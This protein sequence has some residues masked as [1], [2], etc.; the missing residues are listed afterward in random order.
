[1]TSV[2]CLFCFSASSALLAQPKRFQP[3]S[4]YAHVGKADQEEGRKVLQIF[5]SRGLYPGQHYLEFLLTILPRRGDERSIPGR[6]WGTHDDRGNLTRI[7]LA[8]GVA[9]QETRLLVRVGPASAA[10][11][12][13]PG[14]DRA[15]QPLSAAALFEPLAGSDVTAFDLEMPFLYWNDFVFEGVSKVRG[16]PA[17]VFLM[18]PPAGFIP[19][20]EKITG[21]RL[22][23]DTEYTAVVQFEEVGANDEPIKTVSTLDL[24]KVDD[25]W[26]VKSIDYRVEATHNKS[27]FTV[28][29]AAENQEFSSALFEPAV[30]ED[31]IQPPAASAL[32]KVGP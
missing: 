13:T 15:V 19:P 5:R 28:T 21:V 7:V 27:R 14:K 6:L 2:V 31:S 3:S 17:H 20:S 30:L 1:M 16:R 8:P 25:Q 24:K 12:F 22:Y 10:W 18:K 29:A 9:G 11:T 23:L 26:I 32:V 4:D